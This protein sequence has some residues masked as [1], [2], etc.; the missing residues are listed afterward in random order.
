MTA[1]ALMLGLEQGAPS[2]A[3]QPVCPWPRQD[4]CE[5][6]ET[7]ESPACPS[8]WPHSHHQH[9]TTQTFLVHL[10]GF[11][12]LKATQCPKSSHCWPTPILIGT[13][14]PLGRTEARNNTEHECPYSSSCYYIVSFHAK[15]T[16]TLT[17]TTLTFLKTLAALLTE[18]N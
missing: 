1:S 15:K 5:E 12:Q 6:H 4:A 14:F 16:Q 13:F 10:C 3:Q 11:K 7:G 2:P 8:P 18:G 17:W 9:V